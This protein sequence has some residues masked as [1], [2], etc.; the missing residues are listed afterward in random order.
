MCPTDKDHL[1]WLSEGLGG[2]GANL[3]MH[4][5][6][7]NVQPNLKLHGTSAKLW[8]GQSGSNPAPAFV[9]RCAVS[10]PFRGLLTCFSPI[11]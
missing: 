4:P 2:L 5:G 10:K 11:L 9:A 1:A 8:A 3:N 6:L 7:F